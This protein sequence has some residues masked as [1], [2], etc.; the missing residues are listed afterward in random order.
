MWPEYISLAR[1]WSLGNDRAPHLTRPPGA[2]GCATG[3]EYYSK[4]VAAPPR[5]EPATARRGQAGVV[6][7]AEWIGEGRLGVD[8][9]V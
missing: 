2:R 3:G 8:I 1:V 5:R 7:E 6:E 9:F 4:R